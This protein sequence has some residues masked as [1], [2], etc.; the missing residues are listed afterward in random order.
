MSHIHCVATNI[1]LIFIILI[2]HARTQFRNDC[3]IV[4]DRFSLIVYHSGNEYID[5]SLLTEY[6]FSSKN[7]ETLATQYILWNLYH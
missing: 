4:K 7:N 1:I 5:Y 3:E 6:L 2:P